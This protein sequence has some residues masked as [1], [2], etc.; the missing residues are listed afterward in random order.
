MRATE[1]TSASHSIHPSAGRQDRPPVRVLAF[2]EAMTVTGP[3]HN[4]LSVGAEDPRKSAVEMRLVTFRRGAAE[5]GARDAFLSAAEGAAIPVEIIREAGPFD[6]RV[7]RALRGLVERLSPDILETHNVKSHFLARLSGVHRLQPWVAFHH[8]YTTIDAKDRAYNQLNR[9]SLRAADVVVTMN[10]PFADLLARQ[11]VSRDRIRILHNAID[12]DHVRSVSA[13]EV[14][15]ARR[16]SGARAG[17]RIVL[18]VGR[19]SSEKGHRDLLDAFAL[20]LAGGRA[21]PLRLTLLGD[22]PERARLEQQAARLGIGEAVTFVGHVADPR[23]FYAAA[24]L[25]VLPSH[26][27]GS[28]NVLLEAMAAGLPCVATRVGGVPEMLADGESGYIVAARKPAA[29]AQRIGALLADRDLAAS[30]AQ[31]GRARVERDFTR[32]VRLDRLRA[33]YC[34][35]MAERS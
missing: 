24:D 1:S 3:A 26:S 33:L 8:G 15:A 6:L 5:A 19:L 29:I 20:L 18:S 32:D 12:A 35:L 14:S 25:F 34:G 10:R 2:L 11:G 13:E 30:L 9:W 27:E 31:A 28:P 7:L 21:G 23:P 4:L 16:A 17:E 22:G